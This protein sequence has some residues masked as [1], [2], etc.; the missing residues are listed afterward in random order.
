MI[1]DVNFFLNDHDDPYN[2]EIDIMIA[3]KSFRRGGYGTETLLLMM[4]YAIRYHGIT[5][6]YAKISSKNTP[7]QQ[8]FQK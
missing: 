7:S 5:R 6:L 8:L 3:E 2:A 1:G 4:D